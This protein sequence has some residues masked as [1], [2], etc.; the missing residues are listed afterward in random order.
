MH[1]IEKDGLNASLWPGGKL[2]FRLVK[3]DDVANIEIHGGNFDLQGAQYCAAIGGQYDTNGNITI[4]DGRIKA[5]G[6]DSGA[7]IGRNSPVPFYTQ[8]TYCTECFSCVRV[9]KLVTFSERLQCVSKLFRN[10][11]RI[12]NV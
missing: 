8:R 12:L 1:V 5:I 9:L 6:G 3:N 11:A 7:G 10:F 4:Y 2:I